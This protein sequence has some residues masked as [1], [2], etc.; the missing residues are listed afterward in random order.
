MC[1][2][3]SADANYSSLFLQTLCGLKGSLSLSP[4]II[5]LNSPKTTQECFDLCILVSLCNVLRS[6][7]F[8]TFTE[9]QFIGVM[10][11][12]GSATHQ[13]IHSNGFVIPR[14]FWTCLRAMCF[15]LIGSAVQSG[16]VHLCV[17][18]PLTKQGS[19]H[20]ST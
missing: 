14:C 4:A 16:Q 13:V 17:F 7:L 5:S 11:H 10:W 9:Y 20:W 19:S 8:I 18:L 1:H 12:G 6:K 2:A 3:S 15:F